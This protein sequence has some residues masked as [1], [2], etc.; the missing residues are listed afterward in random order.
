M[1]KKYS[2]STRACI[3]LHYP[4]WTQLQFVWQKL[5]LNLAQLAITRQKDYNNINLLKLSKCSKQKIH[6][7]RRNDKK[8]SQNQILIYKSENE[9][10]DTLFCAL[11][12]NS[13]PWLLMKTFMSQFTKYGP[14]NSN[15]DLNAVKIVSWTKCFHVTAWSIWNHRK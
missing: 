6:L 4:V 5:E 2:N 14:L 9:N 8:K 7:K 12:Y 11:S 13:N 3:Q 10:V 1:K 15:M